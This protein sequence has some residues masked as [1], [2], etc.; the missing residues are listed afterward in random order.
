MPEPLRPLP[1]DDSSR[2][3]DVARPQPA[4]TGETQGPETLDHRLQRATIRVVLRG[5]GHR[6][7]L[8]R[9]DELTK[10]GIVERPHASPTKV[11]VEGDD[12][13]LGQPSS[14]EACHQVHPERLRIASPVDQRR[15]VIPESVRDRPALLDHETFD[16]MAPGADDEVE[17]CVQQ[18]VH[19]SALVRAHEP[20]HRAE[21]CEGNAK[22][23]SLHFTTRQGQILVVDHQEEAVPVGQVHDVGQRADVDPVVSDRPMEDRRP[24]LTEVPETDGGQFFPRIPHT[25]RS[26]VQAVVVC[27]RHDVVAGPRQAVEQ[28]LVGAP[29]ERTAGDSRQGTLEVDQPELKTGKKPGLSLEMRVEIPRIR[30][31]PVEALVAG[32]DQVPTIGLKPDRAYEGVSGPIPD[33]KLLRPRGSRCERNESEENQEANERRHLPDHS[34]DKSKWLTRSAGPS[35]A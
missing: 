22:G 33:S 7:L 11:V 2:V 34:E 14:I 32:E 3:H 28:D 26:E 24:P 20:A 27:A 5:V 4:Q 12:E 8:E 19:L 35:A 13:D 6:A 15:H 30:Q 10:G 21:V 16:E 31:P 9:L 25:L 1:D 18:F 29:G 17:P 23:R